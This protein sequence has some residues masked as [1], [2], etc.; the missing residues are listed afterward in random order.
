MILARDDS[1]MR[2]TVALLCSRLAVPL[3]YV[4]LAACA[5]GANPFRGQT[6]GPFDL[7]ATYAGWNPDGRTVEVRN[8]ERSDILDSLLP[9]WLVAR[10]QAR[11]GRLPLWNAQRAGGS[12]ALFDPTNAE[13]S[14]P[15]AIFTVVPDPAT[16]FYLAILASLVVAGL[17]MHYLVR[18]YFGF[19][20][21]LF[22]GISYMMCGYL[23]AWLFWPHTYTAMWIPWLL[24]AVDAYLARDR[25]LAMA[26]VALATAAMFLGGFPFAVA[27]GLGAAL[28]WAAFKSIHAQPKDLIPN[29]AGVVAG[30]ALGL[31]LAAVPLLTLIDSIHSTDISYRSFGTP[32]NVRDHLGLLVAPWMHMENHV[33]SNMYVGIIALLAAMLGAGMVFM[34]KS[35]VPVPVLAGIFFTGVGFVLVFGLLP[36][37]IGAH[38]PVLSNNNWNRCIVLLDIGVI[39]LAAAGIDWLQARIRPVWAGSLVV[40]L[41]VFVQGMDLGVQFRK[42]NGPVSSA[43]FFP[44]SPEL[45]ALRSRIKPFQYVGQ[46]SSAFMISGT[47]GAIGLGEWHAHSLRTPAMRQ[48]LKAI[49]PESMTT[50]TATQITLDKYRWSNTLLDAAGLCYAVSSDR[51]VQWPELGKAVGKGRVALSPINDRLVRQPITLT[52]NAEIPAIAV[53]L[54]TYGQVGADGRVTL[55]LVPGAGSSGRVPGLPARASLPAEGVRDND[56]AVFQFPTPLRLAPGEYEIQLLYKPGPK[57]KNLTLWSMVDPSQRFYRETE[58]VPGAIEY[59]IYRQGGNGLRPIARGSRISVLENPGCASGAYF[60]P[61]LKLMPPGQTSAKVEL[62]DYRPDSFA[63]GIKAPTP[64]FLVVPMQYRHG[65]RAE[66]NG[67]PKEIELVGGVMPAIAVGGG[68]STIAMSYRPPGLYLGLAISALAA[69]ILLA[70]WWLGRR[71]RRQV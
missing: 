40:L 11:E 33:E 20:A 22:S 56:F 70:G 14:L 36:R 4:V 10:E 61:E 63:V 9:T 60:A 7:L 68:A 15:F 51:R 29:M 2:K 71:R 23:T 1:S 62:L 3:L 12:P 6:V 65:W 41:L 37:E 52:G 54:A 47:L 44:V 55:A 16:G 66:V 57:R 59:I 64:G 34:R 13:L 50:A 19:G 31:M 48:F 26:P 24:L 45:A 8:P 67:R 25:F 21:A 46:D 27:V 30:V 18:R 49:A 35:K 32:Y 17:G 39:L 58:A 28:S 5:L 38:L 42:F 53:R 43:Q 69:L